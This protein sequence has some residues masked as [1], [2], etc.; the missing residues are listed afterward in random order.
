M[1]MIYPATGWINFFKIPTYY[2][3][4]VTGDNDEYIDKS[5]SRVS[6]L[7]KNTYFRRYPRPHRVMFDN[8]FGF[9]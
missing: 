7:F 3:G 6:Q 1:K 4:E 9:K 2:L 5:F 8:G